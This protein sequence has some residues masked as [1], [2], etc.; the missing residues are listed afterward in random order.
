MLVWLVR[1]VRLWLLTASTLVGFPGTELSANPGYVCSILITANSQDRD[2]GSSFVVEATEPRK[3]S[4]TH[5]GHIAGLATSSGSVS[6]EETWW[7]QS[8]WSTSRGHPRPTAL[9]S[10]LNSCCQFA[11]RKGLS[12][13][14]PFI[15]YKPHRI[16]RLLKICPSSGSEAIGLQ[17]SP[18]SRAVSEELTPGAKSDEP[19]LCQLDLR[20]TQLSSAQLLGLSTW[21]RAFWGDRHH[22]PQSTKRTHTFRTRHPHPS[23]LLLL[24]HT[25]R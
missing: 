4:T 12:K 15:P 7:L 10:T 9:P 24:P 18:I 5:P 1:L 21:P 25:G 11:L 23:C 13:P 22:I 3:R 19:P 6:I 2:H 14:L 8:L 17:A 16:I 20:F